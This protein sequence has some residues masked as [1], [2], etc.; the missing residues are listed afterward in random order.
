SEI[1]ADKDVTL[2][3][4]DAAKDAD[5]QG[6]LE[7][8]QAQVYHIDLGNADK[9]LKVVTAAAT[10]ITA[11]PIT[12]AI[13]T[14]APSV[15]RRKKGVVIRDPKETVIISIFASSKPNNFSDDFLLTTLKAMFEKPDVEAQVWKNQSGIHGLA[16]VKSWKLLILW[17]SH[18]NFYNYSDDLA[19]R[20][21]TYCCWYKLK[22]LDNAAD[23]RLRLLEQSVA[24][25]VKMKK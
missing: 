18:H 1:D 16:K 24:V 7:E 9:V 3:E 23:S 5:V 15:A 13:I 4:V 22:L 6:M 11:A 19:G 10:T 21:K 14:A 20:K 2:E 17:S 8:S 25:D 12:A